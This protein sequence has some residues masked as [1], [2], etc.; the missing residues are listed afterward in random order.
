MR[1]IVLGSIESTTTEKGL[2]M[3]NILIVDDQPCVR[4]LLSEMLTREGYRV[5]SVGDIQSM[6]R[7]LRD[8]PPDLVLL[9]LYLNGSK[10]WDVLRDI[11]SIDPN[12]PVLIV[13]AYDSYVNDPRLSQ[14]A[15]YIIKS[16]SAFDELKEKIAEV[17]KNGS[18]H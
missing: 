3:S 16:F 5:A 13:T 11:K 14:A 15:G 1:C 10:G 7:H 6:W 18:S 8:S 9:D 12:L 17:L 4:E 2:A